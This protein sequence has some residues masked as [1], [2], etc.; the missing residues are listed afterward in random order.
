MSSERQPLG[1]DRSL[2]EE[3]T[4]L[5]YITDVLKDGWGVENIV[6]EYPITAG[7]IVLGEN[8]RTKRDKAKFADYLLNYEAN[9]PL[10]IVE[11]KA[12]YVDVHVGYQQAVGYAQQLDVPFAYATNG[13][14]LI[15]HDMITGHD[16]HLHIGDMPSRQEL[17]DRY[18]SEMQMPSGIIEPYLQPYST[19]NGK[20]LRYYQ[21]I[22][23]NKV[24]EAVLKGQ[25][26]IVAKTEEIFSLV[27]E[28][29]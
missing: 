29:K 6:M 18:L 3:T 12:S 27:E 23:V 19:V 11:A 5:R 9:V 4:K 22:I 28:L 2:N 15:E 21:R 8:G 13:D 14:E 16:R 24:V 7:R 25:Q 10:A 17:W 1:F 26:R 20:T